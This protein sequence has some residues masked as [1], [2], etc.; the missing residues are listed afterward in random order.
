MGIV[1]GRLKEEP[2]A[3]S[4]RLTEG[5]K[6]SSTQNRMVNTKY[7]N[8]PFYIKKTK[9]IPESSLRKNSFAQTITQKRLNGF[10]NFQTRMYFQFQ[11]P[12]PT[13]PA[14]FN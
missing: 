14:T 1:R 13:T 2:A 9:L 10:P 11:N 7:R 12:K 3:S 6:E 5:K 4:T 8:A